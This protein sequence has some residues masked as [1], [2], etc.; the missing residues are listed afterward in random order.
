MYALH[1]LQDQE[2]SFDVVTGTLQVFDFDVY[3]LLDL[4]ATLSFV[5]PY[6]AV[7]LSVGPE[8]LTEPFS[9][10]TLV[11]DP[12]ISRWLYINYHVTVSHNVSSTDLVDLETVDFDVILGMD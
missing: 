1:G 2:G 5:N 7:E 10:S 3:A 8:T 4:G 9:V 12:F 11:G 6:I